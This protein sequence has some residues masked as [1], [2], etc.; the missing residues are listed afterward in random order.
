MGIRWTAFD[1]GRS[2]RQEAARQRATAAAAAIRATEDAV[3]LEVE[4]AYRDAE[5]AGRDVV[6]AR[7]SVA[8]AEEARRISADRY[9]SGLLPLTDLLDSEESL[10]EARLAEI[11][12][13]H[14]AVLGRVLLQRA[15]GRLEVPR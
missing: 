10:H 4:R 1:R 15:A 14:D 9:A 13:R 11:A 12:A 2:A 3:R 5:V 7:E 8:A 6:R